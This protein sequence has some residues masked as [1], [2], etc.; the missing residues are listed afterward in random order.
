MKRT[1]YRVAKR[2][3][4][5]VSN[6]NENIEFMYDAVSD[7]F[8]QACDNNNTICKTGISLVDSICFMHK[9]ITSWITV[10]LII[11]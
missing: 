1:H 8:N 3:I 11:N 9:S 2:E 6:E 10:V 5:R 4:E 7:T